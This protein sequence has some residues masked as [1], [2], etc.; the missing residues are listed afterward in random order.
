[1][2]CFTHTLPPVF[3]LGP[4]YY[5][6]GPLYF[7]SLL[8][9]VS[10]FCAKCSFRGGYSLQNWAQNLVNSEGYVKYKSYVKLFC[11]LHTCMQAY[12]NE[13]DDLVS[14][15]TCIVQLRCEI[16]TKIL[17]STHL[18]F[19]KTCF[20]MILEHQFQG[21]FFSQVRRQRRQKVDPDTQQTLASISR[22]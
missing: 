4:L 13:Y 22:L 17:I 5:V 21:S 12:T 8:P 10:S 9:C 3:F 19:T 15:K 14:R 20:K 6:L 11:V 7:A 2:L 16:W 18:S 1:M